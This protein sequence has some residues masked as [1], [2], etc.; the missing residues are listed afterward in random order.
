[1]PNLDRI[2]KNE[3]IDQFK[4]RV[5]VELGATRKTNDLSP[6]GST[7]QDLKIQIEGKSVLNSRRKKVINSILNKQ[8]TVVHT[9]THYMVMMRDATQSQ[10][11]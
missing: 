4:S 11:H 8:Q 10:S 2:M 5:A 9:A 6:L 3:S 7:A 1:M